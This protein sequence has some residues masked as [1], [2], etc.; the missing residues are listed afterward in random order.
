MLI[1]RSQRRVGISEIEVISR[2]LVMP[3]P[4]LPNPLP[5]LCIT[6][7]SVVALTRWDWIEDFVRIEVFDRLAH[8]QDV[9]TTLDSHSLWATRIATTTILP[10]PRLNRRMGII[11]ED[12]ASQPTDSIPQAAGQWGQAKAVY[13]FL[14]N[15]RVTPADLNAG[16]ARDTAGLCRDHPAILVVQDTTSLNMTANRAVAELGPIAS[17]G[18]A[19]G[20]L[21]HT[22][23]AVTPEGLVL[24]VLGQ[25]FWA[26]PQ[27][28]RPGPEEKESGKWIEGI[29][30]A[31]QALFESGR[32]PPRLI[33]V[34]DREGDVYDVMQ[35]ID[36][37]GD[38]AII[39][40]A[41]DR[42]VE[43]PLRTAH[44][45]IRD[46]PAL[47]SRW[48]HVPRS[49]GRG[50]RDAWVE[51]RVLAVELTPDLE[52][53]PHAWPMTW[54]LIEVWEPD[55]PAGAPGLHWRL[56]DRESVAAA[57]EA[58]EEV[59]KYT[60][61]W[62]I[63][64]FHLTLKSGCRVEALR[65]EAWDRL[66]KAVVLDSLVAARVVSLRDSSRA[67][68]EAPAAGLL[69]EEEC[70]VLTARFGRVGVDSGLSLKQAVLWIGRLG[71][72][73]NRKGD[74]MPGVRTLWRGLRDLNLLIEGYRA[75]K[76]QLE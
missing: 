68:P 65:L 59:G 23:L 30:Q 42:R 32:R 44:A 66:I 50:D 67:D 41:Q 43:Q 73:L 74:G 34:M 58:W 28:G 25:Q 47:D 36:D 69:G 72:H 57:D 45:A 24:G 27:P 19:R 76:R 48:M 7:K 16:A 2:F 12:L 10:D 5:R 55:P 52:K 63:E 70:E 31:R 54:T 15:D 56:W 22:T 35:W 64:E 61:R 71:G 60:R 9:A 53:Y 39:R 17:A 46:R 62:P 4:P 21:V 3:R 13:R 40:C 6:H 18:R 26:R 49:P 11:L 51:L 29:D 20:L 8:Q 37:L 14:D 75:A 1:R 38:G 33:H